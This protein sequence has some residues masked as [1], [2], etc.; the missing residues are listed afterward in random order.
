MSR[1]EGDRLCDVCHIHPAKGQRQGMKICS[2]PNKLYKSSG[3][4]HYVICKPCDQWFRDVSAQHVR[5]GKVQCVC[6]EGKK[7]CAVC[8][9]ERCIAV[10]MKPKGLEGGSKHDSS[11][12][13]QSSS[14]KDRRRRTT[15]DEDGSTYD[16]ASV[17]QEQEEE[18]EDGEDL[19]EGVFDEEEL[20]GADLEATPTIHDSLM[21]SSSFLSDSPLSSALTPD[22]DGPGPSKRMSRDYGARSSAASLDGIPSNIAEVLTESEHAAQVHAA[23]SSAAAA[24]DPALSSMFTQ[25]FFH[26]S[27]NSFSAF[28]VGLYSSPVGGMLSTLTSSQQ[29][30]FLQQQQQYQQLQQQHQQPLLRALDI[31]N[32]IHIGLQNALQLLENRQACFA[33]T[34]HHFR[35]RAF[36]PD[37]ISRRMVEITDGVVI[38]GIDYIVVNNSDAMS[39]R[40]FGW[41]STPLAR[42]LAQLREQA[43]GLSSSSSAMAAPVAGLAT[44][45]STPTS[46][47]HPAAPSTASSASSSPPFGQLV[48]AS[49]T[50]SNMGKGIRIRYDA[51]GNLFVLRQQ[52]GENGKPG[53]M[54]AAGNFPFV[55]GRG[56]CVEEP[57]SIPFNQEYLVFQHQGFVNMIRSYLDLWEREWEDFQ[58]KR[59]ASD[60]LHEACRFFQTFLKQLQSQLDCT[61]RISFGHT[62]SRDKDGFLERIHHLRVT[63]VV[64]E[65]VCE[66]L[67][68]K[69]DAILQLKDPYVSDPLSDMREGLEAMHL[70]V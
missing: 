8:K 12:P 4:K 67:N 9:H 30:Q 42:T 65:Y 53:E 25:P 66:E 36:E 20:A 68:R 35:I 1:R 47:A 39:P 59:D 52:P 6:G 46:S 69:L 15:E 40:E 57:V 54:F 26:G 48:G 5:N 37:K 14:P 45:A 16:P 34:G 49:K 23:S 70:H 24:A 33:S 64:A 11:P 60:D 27:P 51:D 21:D 7:R 63:T 10:G 29:Q 13:S 41:L 50:L 28:C 56:G 32:I 17:K 3:C 62:W 43:R 61:V 19:G 55:K 31:Y 38:A 58:T 2:C 22:G 18:E 44:T